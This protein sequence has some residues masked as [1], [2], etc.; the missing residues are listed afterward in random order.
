M[1]QKEGKRDDADYN[2]IMITLTSL[3]DPGIVILPTHRIVLSTDIEEDIFVEKLK[4]DFEVEQGDYKRLKEKL[5]AKKKYAFLVYTYNHNFY[6]I[7]LKEPENSLREIEGSKAYK[8]LDVVI[9][10]KL[11]LNKVLEITDEDILYQR[12]IKYTKSDKELIETVKKGAK[13][14]FILN[15]TLVEELKDVSLSGEKMPQKS[16]YFYPKLMTGN[17][18][19]VHLK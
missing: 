4:A 3:E 18:M 6:L 10:Q 2:Y 8:N 9:L 17:V 14:G 12:N 16:T 5:E 19:Y 7:T 15:P 13:Y 11:V 1:E